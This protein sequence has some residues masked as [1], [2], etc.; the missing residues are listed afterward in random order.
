MDGT[1]PPEEAILIFIVFIS[2]FCGWDWIVQFYWEDR[3]RR[4]YGDLDLDTLKITPGSFLHRNLPSDLVYGLNQNYSSGLRTYTIFNICWLF[5]NTL[6]WS[7]AV[8]SEIT[9]DGKNPGMMFGVLIIALLLFIGPVWFFQ[10]I[11]VK[12]VIAI[13][14]KAE[15]WIRYYQEKIRESRRIAIQPSQP[16]TYH[17]SFTGEA[18]HQP[19]N[20]DDDSFVPVSPTVSERDLTR[21]RPGYDHPMMGREKR[22]ST[23]TANIPYATPH[24]P[25]FLESRNGGQT[26]PHGRSYPLNAYPNGSRH[27]DLIQERIGQARNFEKALRYEAAARL[28]E[29]CQM[30]EEAGKMRLKDIELTNP[31]SLFVLDRLSIGQSTMIENSVI[32]DSFIANQEFPVNN[33][34][35]R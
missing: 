5:L 13:S 31:K 2:F 25:S 1:Y 11:G 32:R 6:C 12:R 29:E 22:K 23:T 17:D 9:V 20:Y 16:K 33:D 3:V 4:R 8:Y 30:W 21:H 15:Y 24:Q 27:H 18:Y 7:A 28:Y 26:G 34:P 35:E 19:R 10:W 14:E